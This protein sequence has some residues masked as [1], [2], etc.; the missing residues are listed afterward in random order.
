MDQLLLFYQFMNGED[1]PEDVA[2]EEEAADDEQHVR[3]TGSLVL[4]SWKKNK[5][6]VVACTLV[7]KLIL[8]LLRTSL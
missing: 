8:Y 3:L 5:E 2:G 6:N 7:I 4:Q 1:E